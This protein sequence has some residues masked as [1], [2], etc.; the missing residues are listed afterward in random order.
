M[1]LILIKVILISGLYC[2]SLPVL[3]FHYGTQRK[4]SFLGRSN[5]NY[6]NKLLRLPLWPLAL[7]LWPLASGVHNLITEKKSVE[8][9]VHV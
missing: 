7:G 6:L 2:S 1:R 3:G 4:R 8:L 5:I 9:N